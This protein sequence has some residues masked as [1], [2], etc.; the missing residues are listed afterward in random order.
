MELKLAF[1]R[2]HLDKERKENREFWGEKFSESLEVSPKKLFEP[3]ATSLYYWILCAYPTAFYKPF[4]YCLTALINYA[5]LQTF[6]EET[7]C[8]SYAHI[9]NLT[10]ALLSVVV[11]FLFTVFW[12]KMRTSVFSVK[13][14]S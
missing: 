6:E 4:F 5:K 10:K 7:V 2:Q 12:T 3:L 1:E 8:A 11:M 14:K 13:S 9:C